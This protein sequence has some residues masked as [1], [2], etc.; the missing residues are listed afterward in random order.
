VGPADTVITLRAAN[1][2]DAPTIAAVH[3][4]SWR[5]A[6]RDQLPQETLDSLD[7]SE[8]EDRWSRIIPSEGQIVL[9]ATDGDAVVGFAHAAAT[10][11]DDVRPGTAQLFAIYLEERVAGTGVGRAL[12]A[13]ATDEMGRTG[14]VRATLWVLET[15][16]RARRFYERAGWTWD[17]SRRTHQSRCSNMPVVRYARTL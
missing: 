6:Y 10:D 3:V 14:F 17:G 1:P 5:W 13:R 2:E 7:V 9:V 15:N 8:R 11:D 16:D 4:S 12:L